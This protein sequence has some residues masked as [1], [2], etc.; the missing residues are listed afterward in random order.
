M[1]RWVFFLI[2]VSVMCVVYGGTHYYV[3]G[4]VLA[5]LGP[6]TSWR[7][8][9]LRALFVLAAVSFPAARGLTA[10]SVNPVTRAIEWLAALWM[11]MFLYVLLGTLTVHILTVVLRVSG[12]LPS[13]DGLLGGRVGV[14]ALVV[15]ASGVG[16]TTLSGLYQAR[17]AAETTV[18]DVPMKNLPPG[19][20][21]FKV[22]H[23]S[24]VHIGVIVGTERLRDLVAQ[25]N[26]LQPDLVLISGDLVDEDAN[27][28]EDLA[29]VLRGFRSPHGV[30]A[31]TGNHEFYAR[32]DE[33]V[34]QAAAGNV[35]FLRNERVEVAG[36]LLV[37]GVDDVT[38][39]QMGG[40]VVPVDQVVGP[41]ATERPTVVMHH[42]PRGIE[43]LVARGVDLILS[44]HTHAGQ[45][46]PLRAI[47]RRIYPYQVG[48]YQ[49]GK[50]LL[51]VS[52]GTGTWGPPMRVNAPPEVVLYRLH[53]APAGA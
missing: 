37:Y 50:T 51:Y 8:W 23:L 42:Q 5:A 9:A 47:S 20:D 33:V 21:G 27:H 45:L 29:D 41:D 30:F 22:A 46:W 19:L 34:R 52:R 15:V 44:G 2:F 39:G 13:V 17:C 14:V 43:P 24:D 26:G 49:L 36:G 18:V 7:L 53:P 35:R 28:L 6:V 4:L 12:L 48:P 10:V 11:G 16:L 3:Y 1:P 40:A 25:V 38:V 31:S 32:V